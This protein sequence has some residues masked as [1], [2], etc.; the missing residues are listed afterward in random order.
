MYTN[1][2]IRDFDDNIN[3]EQFKKDLIDNIDE[4]K[5]LDYN[6]FVRQI[7]EAR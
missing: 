3:T 4:N 1:N 6:S 2:L 5:I 7:Y